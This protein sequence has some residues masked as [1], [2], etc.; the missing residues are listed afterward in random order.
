MNNT[1]TNRTQTD[2]QR[3]VGRIDKDY[4][5]LNYV[6][7]HSPDFKGATGSI[8]EPLTEDEYNE[9]VD[10]FFD[11]DNMREFWQEAVKANKTEQSLSDYIQEWRDNNEQSAIDESYFN[12]YGVQ[13][14]ELLGNDKCFITNCTGGGRC[15]TK[16][17]EFDEI[18][19]QSLIDLINQYED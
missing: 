1:N 14:A 6:F 2:I 18:F 3:L 17:M 5:F 11:E 8:L 15:F 4:Y 10:N 16:D 9:R 13:L 19:D 7:E 12:T